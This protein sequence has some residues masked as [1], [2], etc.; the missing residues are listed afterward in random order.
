[1]MMLLQL[2]RPRMEITA[3]RVTYA[4]R[5]YKS[6]QGESK[7]TSGNSG[8]HFQRN[9]RLLKWDGSGSLGSNQYH[10]RM[11][12]WPSRSQRPFMQG[13]CKS[14]GLPLKPQRQWLRWRLQPSIA[15]ATPQHA[16]GTWSSLLGARPYH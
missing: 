13:F 11:A 3:L 6:C 5:L 2:L 15:P 16:P 9:R 10:Y 7:L 12:H 14:R 1:M 8:E 4:R